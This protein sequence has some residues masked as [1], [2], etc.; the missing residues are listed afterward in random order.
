MDSPTIDGLRFCRNRASLSGE[1]E[2]TRMARLA[3]AGCRVRQLRYRIE[4][5]ESEQGEPILELL[6]E[7][8]FDLTCQRCLQDMQWTLSTNVSLGL[9]RSLQE[10]EGAQDDLDRVVAGKSMNIEGLVEDEVILA[11]PMV[12]RHEICSL[13]ES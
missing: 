7:G 10:L 8:Q 1:V 9:A 11:V 3:G 13:H 5:G 6:I 2:P 12:P 4:G